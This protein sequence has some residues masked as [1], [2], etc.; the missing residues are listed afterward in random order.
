MRLPPLRLQMRWAR[1]VDSDP[2]HRW[3]REALLGAVAAEDAR[4]EPARGAPRIK[5]RRS[6]A[7]PLA[8]P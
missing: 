1:A 4:R 8:V 7:R 5:R 3:F 2:G 6:R